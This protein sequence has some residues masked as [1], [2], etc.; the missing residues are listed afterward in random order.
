MLCWRCFRKNLRMLAPRCCSILHSFFQL[1]C[2]LGFCCYC[3]CYSLLELGCFAL[4]SLLVAC[5]CIY[6]QA[7]DSWNLLCTSLLLSDV[8]QRN[9]FGRA[10]DCFDASVSWVFLLE[11]EQFHDSGS[12]VY[13]FNLI[14]KLFVAK[15]PLVLTSSPKSS[16]GHTGLLLMIRL[17]FLG[18]YLFSTDWT[19]V[20]LPLSGSAEQRQQLLS[21]QGQGKFYT[22][23]FVSA[24]SDL[25]GYCVFAIN[26]CELLYPIYCRNPLYYLLLY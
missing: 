26:F 9:F 16:I 11:G 15:L 17:I 1:D 2:P 4:H 21:Y 7:K 6:M 12:L 10:Q 25:S 14:F 8:L 13:W 19:A 18:G 5:L 24:L 23:H 20:C 22:A 3:H